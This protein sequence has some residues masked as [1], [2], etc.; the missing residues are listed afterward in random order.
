MPSPEPDLIHSER[1]HVHIQ[2]AQVTVKGPAE[3]TVSPERK[4]VPSWPMFTD[5]PASQPEPSTGADWPS[6]E[7]METAHGTP[8]TATK[9]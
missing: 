2:P 5:V 3:A 6:I 9:G 8:E 1:G 7:P 4:E